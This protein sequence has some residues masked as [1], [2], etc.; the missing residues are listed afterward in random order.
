L[1]KWAKD[2]IQTKG[3]N[4]IVAEYQEANGKI[5]GFKI[6]QTPCKYSD[7]VYRQQ[8]FNIGLYD[9]DGKLLEKIEK[10]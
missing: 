7:Q 4:R 10:I 2:W 1:T 9:E 3:S 8:C 5:T 6:R